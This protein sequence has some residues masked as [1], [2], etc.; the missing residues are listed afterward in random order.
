MKNKKISLE[1][2]AVQS[3]VTVMDTQASQTIAGGA[4]LSVCL[5]DTVVFN[6][7][8]DACI[9]WRCTVADAC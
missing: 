4:S 8:V 1:K 7:E 5:A 2:L 9:S 3:F 6:S